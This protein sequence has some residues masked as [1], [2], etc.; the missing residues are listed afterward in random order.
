MIIKYRNEAEMNAVDAVDV[1]SAIITCVVNRQSKDSNG[2]H[3]RFIDKR[4]FLHRYRI[5]RRSQRG[6]K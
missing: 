3:H 6:S 1:A 2:S 5:G 4:T